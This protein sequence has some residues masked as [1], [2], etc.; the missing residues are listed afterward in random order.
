MP[1]LCP[2]CEGS[3]RIR[4]S[5]SRAWWQVLLSRPSIVIEP[6][7]T[8]GGAGV[9]KGSPEEEA[10]LA[11]FDR[12]ESIQALPSTEKKVQ[13]EELAR[14]LSSLSGASIDAIVTGL[15]RDY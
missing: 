8:C 2:S 6:C 7:S 14:Q 9:I 13:W 15:S 12:I 10:V 5:I 1:R 3:R 4:R 11:L